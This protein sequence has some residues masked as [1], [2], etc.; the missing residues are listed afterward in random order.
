M[1]ARTSC[2]GIVLKCKI[3]KNWKIISFLRSSKYKC[4]SIRLMDRRVLFINILFN[5]L[6][7]LDNSYDEES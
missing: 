2:D 4:E 3:G 6:H 7:R 5:Y 1:S